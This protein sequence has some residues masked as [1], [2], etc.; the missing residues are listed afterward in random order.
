[1]HRRLSTRLEGSPLRGGPKA[2]SAAPGSAGKSKGGEM[3]DTL[4][5]L[6]AKSPYF[7]K[8]AEDTEKYKHDVTVLLQ[9]FR[10]FTAQ[11]SAQMR[12]MREEVEALLEK[13]VD[14]SKVLANFEGWPASKLDTLREAT[15][16]DRKFETVIEQLDSFI[17]F[18][19]DSGLR[20]S[21]LLASTKQTVE[22]FERTKEGFSKKVTRDRLFFDYGILERVKIAS[23]CAGTRWLQDAVVASKRLK[24]SQD[25]AK[26][27]DGVTIA[28]RNAA[29]Q[30]VQRLWI[31]WQF[32]Y[33]TYRFAGGHDSTA[34][35]AAMEAAAEIES[36][37]EEWIGR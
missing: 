20:L 22:D 37:P 24:T 19:Q 29:V 11:N 28:E 12:A 27:P 10:A 30:T 8:I 17:T 21:R 15:A 1:M 7:L 3:G 26:W 31:A 5:E 9:K 33:K 2:K 23:V 18:D 25:T 13:L 16:M 4:G 32:Y 34:E 6:S 35:S 14:E 36:Y